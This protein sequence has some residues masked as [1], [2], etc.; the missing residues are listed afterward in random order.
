MLL[1]K[2]LPKL[3]GFGIDCISVSSP[4][5][6]E[7]GRETHRILFEESSGGVSPIIIEDLLLPEAYRHFDEVMVAP[8]PVQNADGVPCMVLGIVNA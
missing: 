4:L 8:L 5:H 1:R 3:K 7:L 2:N 6:R